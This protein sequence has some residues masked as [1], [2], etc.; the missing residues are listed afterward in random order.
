MPAPVVLVVGDANP[1]LLLTGD[2]VPEFGQAEKLVSSADLVLGGSAAIVACGL[3]RLGLPTALAAVV[4]EDLF[5]HFVRAELTDAGVDT[6]W[7]RTD[8]DTPTGLSVV[9][10]AGDRAILTHPGTVRATG[11]EVVDLDL[12]D[13]VRHIHSASYFLQPRLAP[14]LQDLF[15]R[16]RASGAG[17]SLDTNWD[18]QRRWSGVLPLLQHTDVLMPNTAELLAL[19][20]AADVE[21][22]ARSVLDRGCAVA[23][24]AGEAGGVLWEISGEVARVAAPPTEV[25]DTTGAGDSFD[26][27]YIS[28]LLDG[29]PGPACLSRAVQCGSLSTRGVGGTSTQA[30]AQDL[31]LSPPRGAVAQQSRS[32]SSR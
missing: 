13:R 18:P 20:S 29:L 12:L 10:S 24:K 9:L 7:L 27:G 19:T 5:G 6:R 3:A 17:T 30:R 22:A 21:S 8:P 11:P 28:A 2:V 26:A 16:A 32:S 14:V 25:V 31:D 23:L 4:G 15:A 1:D